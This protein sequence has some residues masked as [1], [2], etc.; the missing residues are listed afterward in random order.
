M[1]G[2]TKVIEQLNEM[3][4]ANSKES[5]KEDLNIAQGSKDEIKSSTNPDYVWSDE[6]SDFDEGA[7]NGSE[8]L[9]DYEIN[10]IMKPYVQY[11][12]LGTFSSDQLNK[13]AEKIKLLQKDKLYKEGD[14]ISFILNLDKSTGEGT[15]LQYLLILHMTE[16]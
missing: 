9:Y 13:V 2:Q 4:I 8:D 11:G 3:E 12:Y 14:R 16:V 6:E 1:K 5:K 10:A 15:H 7:G